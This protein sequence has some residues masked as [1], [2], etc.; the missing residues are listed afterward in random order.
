M[1][2]GIA[3]SPQ[4]KEILKLFATARTLSFGFES[5]SRE[6][7]LSAIKGT[8]LTRPMLHIC[9]AFSKTKT[10]NDKELF[11]LNYISASI[12]RTPAF[13]GI[14]R[15][16]VNEPYIAEAYKDAIE[17]F[18]ILTPNYKAPCNLHRL[19][20]LGKE[21]LSFRAPRSYSLTDLSLFSGE[22]SP[23]KRINCALRGYS[24]IGE[25]SVLFKRTDAPKRTGKKLS[26]CKAAIIYSEDEAGADLESFFSITENTSGVTAAFAT[27]PDKLFANLLTLNVGFS[28]NA[29]TVKDVDLLPNLPIA[30]RDIIKVSSAFFSQEAFGKAAVV[31]IAPKTRLKK[32][33][34]RASKNGLLICNAL[35][36]KKAADFSVLSR[37]QIIANLPLN[38][39]N[40][41]REMIGHE[42]DIVT[43]DHTSLTK[44]TH[45]EKIFEDEKGREAA[46]RTSFSIS[47]SPAPYHEA[48]YSALSLILSA[49]RDGFDLKN[50]DMRLSIRASISPTSHEKTG[51][52]VAAILGIYRIETEFC[53]PDENSVVDY[54]DENSEMTLSLRAYSSKPN[55]KNE[56]YTSID[57]I[58][59]ADLDENGLPNLKILRDFAYGKCFPDVIFDTNEQN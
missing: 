27:S 42:A 33:C 56:N 21:T 46:Y 30:Y 17:K 3:L 48:I 5:K 32:I 8:E 45:V 36:F 11:I 38:L 58:L 59:F 40:A 19:L 24:K 14:S 20:S 55:A 37:N 6:E 28:I 9:Q 2:E 23:S 34:D 25:S 29:D 16:L 22:N 41:T 13:F 26:S 47:D 10:F 43:H 51:E 15:L 35:S 53:I 4:E 54:A 12:K 31:V 52:A 18:A 44:E 57:P 49:C 50:G 39:L 1:T 7:L